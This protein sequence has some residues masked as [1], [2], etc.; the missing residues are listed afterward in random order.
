MSE[1]TKDFELEV[2]ASAAQERLEKG[3]EYI[4][5]PMAMMGQLFSV[6]AREVIERFGDEGRETIITAVNKYGEEE[7]SRIA[8]R[9]ASEGRENIFANLLV[10]SDLD[11]SYH[12][13]KVHFLEGG[14][15][16][17][18]SYCPFAEAVQEWGLGEYGKYFCQN[19]DEATVRGYNPLE[20]EAVCE[21]NLTEGADTCVIVY[22]SKELD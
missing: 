9:A 12:K 21:H 8:A 11:N 14:V 10:F 3:K 4:A 2:L 1:G 16:L 15:R 13:S 19:V 6:V 20:Y 22:K 7:G 18:V 17:E 5:K